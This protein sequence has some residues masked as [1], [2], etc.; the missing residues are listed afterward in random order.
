MN[1]R[2]GR[3]GAAGSQL[4]RGQ[5]EASLW[6]GI[7]SG[8]T[9]IKFRPAQSAI[10][11]WLKSHYFHCEAA[12]RKLNEATAVGQKGEGEGVNSGLWLWPGT[13]ACARSQTK[14]TFTKSGAISSMFAWKTIAMTEA[15]IEYVAG[16]KCTGR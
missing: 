13:V 8:S 5:S 3:R 10:S 14:I 9:I 12:E 7:V 11:R 15:T 1:D 2:R 6:P 16:E 4:G